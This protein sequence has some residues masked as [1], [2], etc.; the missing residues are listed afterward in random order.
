MG[1]V[2]PRVS[3]YN[4][5]KEMSSNSLKSEFSKIGKI[6]DVNIMT[7][8][9]G[10]QSAIVQFSTC[11]EAKLA[12]NSLH[13]SV[14]NGHTLSLGGVPVIIKSFIDNQNLDGAM[15]VFKAAC[16]ENIV[17]SSTTRV[18]LLDACFK[19]CRSQDDI[20]VFE[21]SRKLKLGMPKICYDYAI[22][23]H[24]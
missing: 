19:S 11:E 2:G 14:L 21:N 24:N 9:S 6:V 1:L 5:N 7:N 16:A 4:I 15:E 22:T 18:R 17:L 23:V 20:T 13:G 3:V 10:V 12:I 8:R